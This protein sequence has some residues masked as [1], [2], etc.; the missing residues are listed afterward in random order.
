[1]P[2]R[3]FKRFHRRIAVHH[4]QAQMDLIEAIEMP[5]LADENERHRRFN[6]IARRIDPMFGVRVIKLGE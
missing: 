2:V 6:A 3:R 1:M 4:A 5:H